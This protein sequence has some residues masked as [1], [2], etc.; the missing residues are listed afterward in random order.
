MKSW[1]LLTLLCW[2]LFIVACKPITRQEEPMSRENFVTTVRKTIKL[3][4]NS[5]DDQSETLKHLVGHRSLKSLAEVLG[6]DYINVKR[7]RVYLG[8]IEEKIENV[9]KAHITTFRDMKEQMLASG[10]TQDSI[11]ELRIEVGRNYSKWALK[12]NKTM[13]DT[14]DKN[15]LYESTLTSERVVEASQKE[16]VNECNDVLELLTSPLEL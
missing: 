11:A 6:N 1:Y 5:L 8:W 13:K 9:R 15:H 10:N 16:F 2:P 7:S 12:A 14:L 4:V 3:A